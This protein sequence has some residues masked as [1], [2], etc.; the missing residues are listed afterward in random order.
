[1]LKPLQIPRLTL[2]DYQY[3][4]AQPPELAL[5]DLIP[6]AITS[7]LWKPILSLCFGLV[8]P[9][10]PVH[11]PEA[12]PDL[13]NLAKPRHNDIGLAWQPS[14][15]QSESVAVTVDDASDHQFRR[16]IN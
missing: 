11:M 15:M 10:A 4:P 16:C 12:S 2:P 1:M 3:V 8:G 13:D 14:Y 5:R 7:Q 6:P 9:L